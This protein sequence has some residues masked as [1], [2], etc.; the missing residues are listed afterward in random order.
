MDNFFLNCDIRHR[1]LEHFSIIKT[2]TP[3]LRHEAVV[4]KIKLTRAKTNT[5]RLHERERFAREGKAEQTIRKSTHHSHTNTACGG[6]SPF[7]VNG[8]LPEMSRLD[9]CPRNRSVQKTRNALPELRMA[10]PIRGTSDSRDR[11]GTFDSTIHRRN[12]WCHFQ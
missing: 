6:I 7:R 11:R 10:T 3:L 12:V 1:P 5:R 9:G 2:R 4:R 8:T